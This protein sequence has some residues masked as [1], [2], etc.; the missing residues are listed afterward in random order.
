MAHLS[1]SWYN[2]PVISDKNLLAWKRK[3]SDAEPEKEALYGGS[4]STGS[5]GDI[6]RRENGQPNISR[7]W[8][9]FKSVVEV[10]RSSP[11]RFTQPL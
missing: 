11:H 8:D 2:S 7:I 9:T 3:K 1:G 4:Q 5:N 6:K 10:E